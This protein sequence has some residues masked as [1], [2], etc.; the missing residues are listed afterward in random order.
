MFSNFVSL[1]QFQLN[2]AFDPHS[3]I[4]YFGLETRT[5]RL[6]ITMRGVILF[7]R[8]AQTKCS[9]TPVYK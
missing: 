4:H 9:H 7:I 2:S 3:L 6:Y 5:N 1:Y 8:V